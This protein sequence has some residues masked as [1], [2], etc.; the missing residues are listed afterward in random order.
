MLHAS[1]RHEAN[2]VQP[3]ATIAQ[4]NARTGQ[5]HTLRFPVRDRPRQHQRELLPPHTFI[6]SRSDAFTKNRHP[7]RLLRLVREVR[8]RLTR[9]IRHRQFIKFHDYTQWDIRANRRVVA[10]LTRASSCR[11]NKPSNRA[12]RAIHQ[13]RF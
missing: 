11:P 9:R 7:L 1:S 6:H 3:C 13:T 2:T 12:E 8:S 4:L 10:L 5:R